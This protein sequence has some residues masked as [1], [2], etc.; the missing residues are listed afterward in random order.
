[1]ARPL[2]QKAVKARIA[3]NKR[4]MKETKKAVTEALARGT[5]GE[6]VDAPSARAA[7]AMF[8]KSAKAVAAD[9]AKLA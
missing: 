9:T 5:K 1:M 2:D 7:L 4:S 6:D 3:E 8:I